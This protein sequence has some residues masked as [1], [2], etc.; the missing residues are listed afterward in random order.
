MKFSIKKSPTHDAYLEFTFIDNFGC[1]SR[2]LSQNLNFDETFVV[3][4][5]DED[6][7]QLFSEQLQ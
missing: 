1:M 2:T 5:S 3:D 4:F 7:D 6:G